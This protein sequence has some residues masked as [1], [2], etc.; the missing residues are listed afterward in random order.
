MFKARAPFADT[1]RSIGGPW[2]ITTGQIGHPVIMSTRH[3]RT[4]TARN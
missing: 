1:N 2:R 4:V 3:G